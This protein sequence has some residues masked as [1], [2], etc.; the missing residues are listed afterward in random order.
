MGVLPYPDPASWFWT[1][2]LLSRSTC[3]AL[4]PRGD[5]RAWRALYGE[6]QHIAG[7]VCSD[8]ARRKKSCWPEPARA[9]WGFAQIDSSTV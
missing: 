7:V 9:G 1:R 3:P 6:C 2:G 4:S 8:G 5:S